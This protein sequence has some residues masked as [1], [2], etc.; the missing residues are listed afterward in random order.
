MIILKKEPLYSN[1]IVALIN[2]KAIEILGKEKITFAEMTDTVNKTVGADFLEQYFYTTSYKKTCK[3][4][5]DKAKAIAEFLQIPLHMIAHNKKIKGK[6]IQRNLKSSSGSVK[7]FLI[8]SLQ[9]EMDRKQV[10]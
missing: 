7:R 4:S 6:K 8:D 1:E 9:R 2:K 5:I 3:I 10:K